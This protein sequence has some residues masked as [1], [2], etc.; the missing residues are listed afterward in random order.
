MWISDG[1]DTEKFN[2]DNDSFSNSKEKTKDKYSEMPDF[3]EKLKDWYEVVNTTEDDNAHLF[4]IN[5]VFK[6]WVFLKTMKISSSLLSEKTEKNLELYVFDKYWKISLYNEYW[7]N[8]FLKW[9]R[10]NVDKIYFTKESWQ[11][12]LCDEENEKFHLENWERYKPVS[13]ITKVIGTARE[14]ALVL[15][16]KNREDVVG[17]KKQ[18]Q[19]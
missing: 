2:T 17:L 16:W 7:E 13:K 11:K 3:V 12:I 1:F 9:I 6:Q 19:K 14:L 18:M 10:T 15:L 4:K 8:V 5:W